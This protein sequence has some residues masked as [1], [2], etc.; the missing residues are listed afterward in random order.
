V[1]L[2]HRVPAVVAVRA[3]EFIARLQVPLHSTSLPAR[4]DSPGQNPRLAHDC[5]RASK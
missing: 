5:S 4:P 2:E 1:W 3:M